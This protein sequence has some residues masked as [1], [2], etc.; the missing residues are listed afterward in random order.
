MQP[1]AG[2]TLESTAGVSSAALSNTFSF[3]HAVNLPEVGGLQTNVA[4]QASV[5]L[6]GTRY[7][8]RT[9]KM[10]LSSPV[11]VQLHRCIATLTV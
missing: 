9:G 6:P 5:R 7:D 1:Y 11:D 10:G 3:N 2:F 4:T 8:A